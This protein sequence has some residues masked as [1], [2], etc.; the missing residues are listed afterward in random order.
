MRYNEAMFKNQL[1]HLYPFN[2]LCCIA[3]LCCCLVCAAL[4]YCALSL[5]V[6]LLIHVPA[7]PASLPCCFLGH[8]G[9]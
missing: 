4:F 9:V 5:T 1:V 3:K 6:S 7:L 8:D 2:P